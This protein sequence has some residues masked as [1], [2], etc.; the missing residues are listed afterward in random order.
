MPLPPRSPPP[1]SPYHQTVAP[2][3]V[4]HVPTFYNSPYLPQIMDT[5]RSAASYQ[6]E[7]TDM[8]VQTDL[9]LTPEGLVSV[10]I[11]LL[12]GVAL[13]PKKRSDKAPDFWLYSP[14]SYQIKPNSGIGIQTDVSIELPM[15]EN[16]QVIPHIDAP[17]GAQARLENRITE[18]GSQ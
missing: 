11:T 7:N 12:S 18:P 10:K 16:G 6:L 17:L 8:C 15:G 4:T 13:P 3:G 5:S 1:P 2:Y 9:S 14:N